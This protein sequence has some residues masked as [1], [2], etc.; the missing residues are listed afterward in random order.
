MTNFPL[1]VVIAYV[2]YA[3]NVSGGPI[4]RTDTPLPPALSTFTSASSFLVP[5]ATLSSKIGPHYRPNEPQSYSPD[6]S[7]ISSDAA[8]M[9]LQHGRAFDSVERRDPRFSALDV[10]S[11]TEHSASPSPPQHASTHTRSY[12]VRRAEYL[13]S[14]IKVLEE[15]FFGATAKVWSDEFDLTFHFLS[16]SGDQNVAQKSN[17]LVK[18]VVTI[19]S[20]T[21]EELSKYPEC[22]KYLEKCKNA[23]ERL[24]A[25]YRN[26]SSVQITTPGSDKD[27]LFEEELKSIDSKWQVE[28]VTFADSLVKMMDLRTE[29]FNLLTS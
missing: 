1:F 23:A 18:K 25:L 11:P 27:K 29:L 7:F 22:P 5:E 28:R 6:I 17:P 26:P 13:L 16:S 24:L 20:E 14:Q 10:R 21:L 15:G 2:L 8:T 9:N 3:G 12:T 4:P 19:A